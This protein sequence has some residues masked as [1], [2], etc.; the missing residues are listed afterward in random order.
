MWL[1]FQKNAAIA[2]I[3]AS[4]LACTEAK[5]TG[6]RGYKGSAWYDAM[7]FKQQNIIS[8]QAA[9]FGRMDTSS[10]P[11]DVAQR[12]LLRGRLFNVL[13]TFLWQTK[14]MSVSERWGGVLHPPTTTSRLGATRLASVHA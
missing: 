3:P 14:A 7:T 1:L 5:L 10:M 13:T 8:T 11:L 6:G 4:T 12:I 2:G 9:T